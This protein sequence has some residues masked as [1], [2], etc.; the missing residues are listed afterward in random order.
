MM[1]RR[2][3]RTLTSL[4]GSLSSVSTPPLYRSFST[5]SSLSTSPPASNAAAVASTA[6]AGLTEE[7]LLVIDD[8]DA[9]VSKPDTIPTLLQPGVV[10]YDGVCHLCHKGVKWVIRADKDRKIKFCCLQ[11]KAAEPYMSLCGVD[12]NDVLRRFLFIEGPAALKVLS[13]LPLPYSIL[14][15]FMIIPPPLRDAVYDYIAKRRYHWFGKDDD[16]LVLQEKEL[17][18]RFIDAEEL[19]KHRQSDS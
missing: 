10:V 12:R 19:L 9:A 17:L 13:H 18:E 6:A 2:G 5:K 3:V 7:D 8:D 11:S 15:T 16:C 1:L 14:S 4:R